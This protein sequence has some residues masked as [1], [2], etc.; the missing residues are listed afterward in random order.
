VEC[1]VGAK[2]FA[3]RTN[4][5][6]TLGLVL[7]NVEAFSR[8]VSQCSTTHRAAIDYCQLFLKTWSAWTKQQI[9]GVNK[10]IQDV[11]G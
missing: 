6:T 1:V 2:S 5:P 4:N 9:L 8:I 3:P 11:E 10:Q 7:L